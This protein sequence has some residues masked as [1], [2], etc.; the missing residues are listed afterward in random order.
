MALL[1]E[2]KGEILQKK[3]QAP[4]QK[5]AA[6]PKSEKKPKTKAEIEAYRQK[7]IAKEE[8]RY[9]GQ[10]EAAPTPK[11]ALKP[12]PKPKGKKPA[13]QMGEAARPVQASKLAKPKPKPKVVGPKQLRTIALPNGDSIVLFYVP[14]GAQ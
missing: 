5:P 14:G 4:V 2:I 3:E 12:S 11:P 1:D 13:A 6:K 7:M 8:A 9:I 10:Q